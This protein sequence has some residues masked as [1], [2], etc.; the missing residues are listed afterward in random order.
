MMV[1][2]LPIGLTAA[3]KDKTSSHMDPYVMGPANE[4]A[5]IKEVR[6]AL[7]MLPY[8]GVFDDLG[9]NVDGS[10]VTLTGQVNDPTLKNDAGNAVKKIK[11]VTNVTNNIEVLPL[12]PTTR[13][14][15]PPTA[16][17]TTTL[18]FRCAM[19]TGPHPPFI[20]S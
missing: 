9:F 17:F 20:S 4:S 2:A 1:L 16:L 3:D 10:N 8:Y 15:L 6:H 5:L 18:C 12:S 13:S 11:D 14:V 7:L 19:P